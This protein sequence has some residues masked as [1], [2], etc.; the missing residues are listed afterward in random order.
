M[1][2][3]FNERKAAQLAAFFIRRGGGVMNYTKLLK[4]MYLADRAKLIEKGTPI[5]G[6]EMFSLPHGPV[7][8]AV[9]NLV[10]LGPKEANSDWASF[11]EKAGRFDVRALSQSEEVDELSAAEIRIATTVF[12]EHGRMT[13]WQLRQFT[14]TLPE[15]VDPEGSSEPIDL[16]RIL[17]E[18]GR[19]NEE[20]ELSN[21]WAAVS[22][23]LSQA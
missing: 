6:D 3:V 1:R 7:L 12:E 20:I 19:S 17:R 5:T 13:W 2:F 4:L 10:R 14:H 16:E 23:W 9:C 15:Y 21:Q 22:T 18:G 11:V 8:S